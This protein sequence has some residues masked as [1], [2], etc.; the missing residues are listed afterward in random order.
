MCG[1]AGIYHFDRER[2]VDPVILKKMI[3]QM[4]HRGPDGEGLVVREQC[5]LAHRRLAIQDPSPSGRQPMWSR[6]G[7]VWLVFNG[8]FFGFRS[9]RSEL[10]KRGHVFRSSGDSEVVL[11][12]YQEFGLDFLEHLDGMF[13][14]ALWDERERML[15]VARDRLGIKPLYFSME[16]RLLIFASELKGLLAHPAVD[17]VMDPEALNR[18]F[19]Y[20][21][22]PGEQSIVSR[23]SKLSP[24]HL[25]TARD[26][27]VSIR[28]YWELEPPERE[29]TAG[30]EE[31]DRHLDERLEKAVQSHLV[32]DVPVGIF[33]SGGLDSSSVAYW[34]GRHGAEPLHSFSIAF[35]R[36]PSNDE[37]GVAR[38]IAQACGFRHHEIVV[39]D[40]DVPAAVR[41][42]AWHA[43]EP[44]AI[45]SAV[46]V[47]LLAQAA[48]DYV[49]VALTGDGGDEIF[50]GYPWRHSQNGTAEEY[51]RRVLY[52]NPDWRKEL[53][54]GDFSRL[55]GETE[56]DDLL[57]YYR[58]HPSADALWKKLYADIKTTLVDEM[59]TK[60]DRMTM[61]H[62][63][64]GRIP[65]LDYR[66]VEWAMRLPAALKV[67]DGIGKR[68]VR[69]SAERYYGPLVASRKKLGFNVPSAEWLRGPLK[70]IV[71]D[72]TSE[73][74]LGRDGLLNPAVARRYV[75]EHLA[76]MDR[77]S[78]VFALL[79]FGLWRESYPEVRLP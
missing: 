13:A 45:G 1:L 71:L 9:W 64:E 26:G 42:M 47:Y 23:V 60:A 4:G 25:L 32:S 65:L 46:G 40:A 74:R 29:E 78:Y 12:L 37:S 2:P 59:L 61:A 16:D 44:F 52:V 33:L 75:D 10:A 31:A 77:T 70:S 19:A 54:R 38:H 39:N 56:S 11:S 8:E 15:V 68:I 50:G 6:N 5:G 27:K 20:L 41:A 34:A 43:D 76:G 3:D 36:D 73:E 57:R 30:L 18:Y 49:K 17:P 53:Y 35:P 72:L 67:R 51:R 7:D 22:V 63:I 66:L 69:A 62:G 58:L 14:L 24:G 79:A 48:K 21:T 28:R 55:V